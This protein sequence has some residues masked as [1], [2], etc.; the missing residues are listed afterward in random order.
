MTK[1]NY[2]MKTHNKK[3]FEFYKKNPS[4]DFEQINILCVDLFE[5]ILQDA[6][7]EMNKSISSQILLECTENK[8]KIL[9]L[10]NTLNKLSNDL[11]LRSLDIK[12]DYIEEV[13]TIINTNTNNTTDKI[14]SLIEKSNEQLLDKTYISNNNLINEINT[15]NEKCN[16]TWELYKWEEIV[17]SSKLD[18]IKKKFCCQRCITT[19]SV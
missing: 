19:C 7:N 5:N 8:N 10:N 16:N 6:N 13:K 18:S 4:L 3:V 11:L 12:R 14:K 15:K 9:E 1:E 17:I 2:E